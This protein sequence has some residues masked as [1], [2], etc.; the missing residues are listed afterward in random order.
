MYRPSLDRVSF[1]E[2]SRSIFEDS[3]L[4]IYPT[5]INTEM[6]KRILYACSLELAVE[7]I[8]DFRR[9]I[10]LISA[11]SKVIFDEQGRSIFV[12]EG[13]DPEI[14]RVKDE[15]Q[16]S[17]VSFWIK[18]LKNYEVKIECLTNSEVPVTPQGSIKTGSIKTESIKQ[19]P[20]TPQEPIKQKLVDSKRKN[21]IRRRIDEVEAFYERRFN[22]IQVVIHSLS[23]DGLM[24]ILLQERRIDINRLEDMLFKSN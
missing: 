20:I 15:Y 18:S 7:V 16:H 14:Y 12:V 22:E 3:L 11:S 6:I 13:C 9:S 23:A 5:L 21:D 24:N 1:T 4:L 2:I 17:C 19:E 10:V 8:N